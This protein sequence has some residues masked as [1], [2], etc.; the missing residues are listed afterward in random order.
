VERN[1][2]QLEAGASIES[3]AKAKTLD[4]SFVSR[5]LVVPTKLKRERRVPRPFGEMIAALLSLAPLRTPRARLSHAHGR[6]SRCQFVGL[7][8]TLTHSAHRE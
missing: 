1:G 4:I 3:L 6:S 2:R 7:A 8:Q 5:E